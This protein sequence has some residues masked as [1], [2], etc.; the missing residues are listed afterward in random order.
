[1]NKKDQLHEWF[2]K[3]NLEVTDFGDAFKVINCVDN[4]YVGKEA[5]YWLYNISDIIIW[6]RFKYSIH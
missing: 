2:I 4:R 5:F 3:N 6:R 1:M